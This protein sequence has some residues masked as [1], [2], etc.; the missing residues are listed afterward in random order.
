[1]VK[2]M[3]WARPTAS[4]RRPSRLRFFSAA[5]TLSDGDRVRKETWIT[6]VRAAE[7]EDK[8]VSTKQANSRRL[9]QQTLHDFR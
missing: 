6:P 1:M 4:S 3:A 8:Y 2:L 9:L 7:E 5:A